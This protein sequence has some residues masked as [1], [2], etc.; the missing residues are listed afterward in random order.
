MTRLTAPDTPL[1]LRLSEAS[2]AEQIER[3]SARLRA[4]PT[5]AAHRWALFQLMCVTGEWTRAIQ[6][7][8]TWARLEPD[9]A[10]TAQV[11]RDLIRAERWRRQVVEGHE[12]PG[13]VLEPPAWVDG[14]L[15]A[16]RFAAN[17]QTEQA[18]DARET[19]FDVAPSRPIRIPEGKA[20]WIVDSDSRFGPVCEVITAG[21]YRWVPFA[22]L[23]AW[24]V[25]PPTKPIDLVWAPCTLTLVDGAIVHG[26]MPAR[27]PNSEAG[28]DAMRLG[29]TTVWRENGR[30]GIT[31]LGQKTWATDQGDFGLFELANAEFGTRVAGAVSLGEQVDD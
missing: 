18:D 10:A 5:T 7:L 24:R 11:Y 19:V 27:Y 13:F 28:D 6:Q 22:D 8:Q 29:H 20:T 9:Q 30:T 2:L 23:A 1:T 4:Q 16:L 31:A 17:G 14:L 12:R 3:V 15:D 26:F 21:H 25:S